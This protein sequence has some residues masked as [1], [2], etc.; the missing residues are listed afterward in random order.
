MLAAGQSVGKDFMLELAFRV[1][2]T[3]IELQF[4]DVNTKNGL[5]Y[6]DALL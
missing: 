4:D 1:D 5:C 6:D 3:D 2:E